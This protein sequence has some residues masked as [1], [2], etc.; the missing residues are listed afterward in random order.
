MAKY[1]S[2]NYIQFSRHG[3]TTEV[4]KNLSSGAFK[5]FV[6]LKELEHRFTGRN[7]EFF[8]YSDSDLAIMSGL[9][10]RSVKAYRKELIESGLIL[11]SQAHFIDNKGK[12]SKERISCY[13]ILV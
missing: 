13:K 5:M 9:S 1:Q 11:Y 10:V 6:F 3:F 12:K 8:Y 7:S 2:G 4:Y